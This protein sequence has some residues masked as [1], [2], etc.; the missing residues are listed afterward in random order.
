MAFLNAR[1]R[2]LIQFNRIEG[3][4]VRPA[5]FA[6]ALAA[7]VPGVASATVVVDYSTLPSAG[8]TQFASAAGVQFYNPTEFTVGMVELL[9]GTAGDATVTMSLIEFDGGMSDTSAVAV[10]A[11][12]TDLASVGASMREFER[13]AVTADFSS[14]DIT[15]EAD[16]VYGIVLTDSSVAVNAAIYASA[17]SSTDRTSDVGVIYSGSA[18]VPLSYSYMAGWE[19]PFAI[20][21]A[22][23]SPVPLPAPVALL[24]AGLAGLGLVARRRRG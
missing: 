11:S 17:S 24:G 8:P 2:S 7:S 4:I 15:L 6:A 20:S 1:C 5:V 9:M 3:T 13:D 18:G 12:I 14:F 23:T 19:S 22:E 21:A 16:R 10:L